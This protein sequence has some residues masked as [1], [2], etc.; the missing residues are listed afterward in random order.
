MKN[1]ESLELPAA[2]RRKQSSDKDD[3]KQDEAASELLLPADAVRLVAVAAGDAS[4]LRFCAT[5]KTYW[6]AQPTLRA[7]S[8]GGASV[9]GGEAR[10]YVGDGVSSHSSLKDEFRLRVDTIDCHRIVEAMH[11]KY[12]KQITHLFLEGVHTWD[13]SLGRPAD[14]L[15]GPPEKYGQHLTSLQTLSV[16]YPHAGHTA[17]RSEVKGPCLSDCT[18]QLFRATSETL[19]A[20]SISGG[21]RFKAEDACELLHS[22]GIEN[23]HYLELHI[24]PFNAMME[25]A[26]KEE[27]TFLLQRLAALRCTGLLAAACICCHR[28]RVPWWYWMTGVNPGGHAFW[29]R[30]ETEQE[31]FFQDHHCL[32]PDDAQQSETTPS[33]C[34]RPKGYGGKWC[35]NRLHCTHGV[36]PP[37]P[38]TVP[39]RMYVSNG[40]SDACLAIPLEIHQV[41]D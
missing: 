20:L 30:D 12:A 15:A 9:W 16:A 29:W 35:R 31:R 38:G 27:H 32:Y 6:G 7:L 4:A 2:K 21:S 26:G 28:L 3:E 17:P 14:L 23:L 22:D 39:T 5:C 37:A 36:P 25:D 11:P 10:H 34:D 24:V 1:T 19:R 40:L 8:V 18:L 41:N 13:D 33:I